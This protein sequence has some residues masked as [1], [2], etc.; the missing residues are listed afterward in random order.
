MAAVGEFLPGLLA[1]RLVAL[2]PT[3]VLVYASFRDYAST[4]QLPF[5]NHRDYLEET[6]RMSMH[7]LPAFRLLT[8][9]HM[10]QLTMP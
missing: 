5:G 4:I 3:A 6:Q 2:P 7:R 9:R 1:Y 8:E 10:E